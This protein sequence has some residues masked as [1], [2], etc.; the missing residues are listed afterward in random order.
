M[1]QGPFSILY[2]SM[3]MRKRVRVWTRSYKHVRGICS[4]VVV[5]FDKHFN[6]VI[7]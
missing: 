6:M 2:T 1:Q 3:K 4:G 5:A 7:P